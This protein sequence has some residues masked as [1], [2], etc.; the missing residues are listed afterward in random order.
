MKLQ[1]ILLPIG[2]AFLTV[3]TISYFWGGKKVEDTAQ[4]RSGQQF[5]VMP[6][7][8]MCQP[9][10]M[11]INFV[12]TQ[13]KAA[14]VTTDVQGYH[15]ELLFSSAGATLA[16]LQFKREFAGLQGAM[17]TI[18]SSADEQDGGAFLVALQE[19]TPF[20]FT[21]IDKKVEQDVVR[22]KYEGSTQQAKITK[23]FVVSL[24]NYKIDLIVTLEPLK[25]GQPLEARIFIPGPYMINVDTTNPV[26]AYP[27]ERLQAVSGVVFTEREAL[28]KIS[29]DTIE[30][31]AWRAPQIFGVEDRYFVHA[32]VHD[33]DHFTQRAY[34]KRHDGNHLT[35]I[36]E[37]PAI[38]E[39]TTWTLSF[40]C[41]PKETH[42]LVAVD[43]RLESIMDYG[44]LAPISKFL[45][46]LLNLIYYYIGNYGWAIIILTVLMRLLMFPFTRSGERNLRKQS[47]IADKMKYLT[48]K[49]KDDKEGLRAAQAELMKKH[50]LSPLTG[51]L[52]LLLQI[53]VFIGLNYALRNSIELYHAPFIF[54]IRDL[55]VR[56]PYYV[57]PAFVG[58]TFFWAM[59]AT[60]KD[61]R[62]KIAMLVLS[63]VLA[64]V[65]ANV[66]AGL[67]LF[68]GVSSLLGVV[69]TKLNKSMK[70]A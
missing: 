43:K 27:A 24:K 38:T 60:S 11:E 47:E 7:T 19:A 48:Q 42:E 58:L 31:F 2:L 4:V 46:F 70:A 35:A 26:P 8:Q 62:H 34:Y 15:E 63:C 65:M 37:G 61:P 51:C 20:A 44:W 41:G 9:V 28:E 57:I 14:P 6:T 29:V 10:N 64:G 3:W 33:H 55:S 5:S 50:G 13:A 32:M 36:L 59:S 49:Y 21:F 30:G 67:G 45:L 53:P 68:I 17:T 56:D 39:K 23:E 69:Q 66:S 1:E 54:W 25:K 16:T 12:D 52:P 40:Y 22:I 18:S